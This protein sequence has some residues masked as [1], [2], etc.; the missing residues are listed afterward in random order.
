MIG[1]KLIGLL[2]SSILAGSKC[3]RTCNSS[4]SWTLSTSPQAMLMV[5]I[6]DLH[7]LLFNRI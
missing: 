2:T 5:Q 6:V 4:Q 3:R 7:A 1:L